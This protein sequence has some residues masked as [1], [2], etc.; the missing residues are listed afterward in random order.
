MRPPR[1]RRIL[2]ADGGTGQPQPEG[3]PQ[4]SSS[5]GLPAA[6]SATCRTAQPNADGQPGTSPWEARPPPRVT[7]PGRDQH[8]ARPAGHWLSPDPSP[9]LRL[10]WP[11]A[12][13]ASSQSP[14]QLPCAPGP[15]QGHRSTSA[16][17]RT[18]QSCW[19]DSRRW[20]CGT[21]GA[22]PPGG[23]ATGNV[24]CHSH[25]ETWTETGP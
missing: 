9:I 12:P 25:V 13:G 10:P 21:V 14:G 22:Q 1:P 8:L 11:V 7:E 6:A 18:V 15:G 24:A 4:A 17:P 19:E 5:P 3:P 20:L 16:Q 23:T 2:H